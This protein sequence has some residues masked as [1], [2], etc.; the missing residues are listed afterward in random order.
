MRGT[1]AAVTVRRLRPGQLLETTSSGPERP[2]SASQAEMNDRLSWNYASPRKVA[3]APATLWLSWKT[4][5]LPSKAA[6]RPPSP[7]P[8]AQHDP[9]RAA[10][11]LGRRM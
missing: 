8:T 5:R 4:G 11:Q 1:A 2:P 9:T 3:R 10:F 6:V 7:N